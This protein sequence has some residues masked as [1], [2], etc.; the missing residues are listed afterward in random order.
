MTCSRHAIGLP[1]GCY[2]DSSPKD[3][4]LRGWRNAKTTGRIETKDAFGRNVV[5]TVSFRGL[6][7]AL[8]TLNKEP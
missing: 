6:S 3:E 7:Q 8:D 2:V 4:V 5:V 1:N